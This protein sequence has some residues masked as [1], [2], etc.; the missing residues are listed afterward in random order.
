[1]IRGRSW[2]AKGTLDKLQKRACLQATCTNCKPHCQMGSSSSGSC[3]RD[4][5]RIRS[6]TH[7]LTLLTLGN[8]HISVELKHVDNLNYYHRVWLCELDTVCTL[9]LPW[10][11]EIGFPLSII[12]NNPSM[13]RGHLWTV[14]WM[15]RNDVARFLMDNQK[16]I[17]VM[18]TGQCKSL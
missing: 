5:S 18:R 14:M 15:S 7:S 1:M 12:P 9:L 8:N 16:L 10:R 11:E 13:T 17:S 6:F 4:L 2:P 3:S